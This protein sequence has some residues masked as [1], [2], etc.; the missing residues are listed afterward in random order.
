MKNGYEILYNFLQTDATEISQCNHAIKYVL[1]HDDTQCTYCKYFKLLLRYFVH[2]SWHILYYKGYLCA[3]LF[4]YRIWD[5]FLFWC[6]IERVCSLVSVGYL[7]S[8]STSRSFRNNDEENEVDKTDDS[9]H[10][11]SSDSDKGDWDELKHCVSNPDGVI[12]HNSV[13]VDHNT[14]VLEIPTEWHCYRY[15]CPCCN[16]W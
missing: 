15:V 13:S 12:C 1:H 11:A 3:L 16:R 7:W 8:V 10:F 2:F 9:S 14:A 5:N 6:S 4:R